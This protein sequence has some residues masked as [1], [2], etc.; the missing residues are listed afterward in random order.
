MDKSAMRAAAQRLLE[1]SLRFWLE[2]MTDNRNGGFYGRIDGNGILHPDAP[3]GAVL[4]ARILWSF[5][6]AYR[7]TRN[8]QYLEAAARAEH[9]LLEKF[10]DHDF[11]GVY[12]SLTADGKPLD[13]RKQIYALG[14]AVYGLSEYA[15]ATGD[16][17]AEEAAVKL[18]DDIE[19]HSFDSQQNGY[20]EAF[21]RQWNPIDDMRLSEKDANECKTMNT[22]LHIMEPYTNLYRLRRDERL[23]ERLVNLLHIFSE[24]I[25]DPRN[26]HL[27]LFFDE[28]WRQAERGISYG[29][30]IEASW[31]LLEA[32]LEIG[33]EKLTESVKQLCSIIARA[34]GEGLRP[35]GSMIYERHADGTTDEERHW[36]VQA[37]NTVGQLWL[38]RYHNDQEAARRAAESL[39]YITRQIA[40][41]DGEWLWGRHADG[42]PDTE[43]DLAGFWKCP[44]HNTRMCLEI[45]RLT[46]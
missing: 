39:D 29:H 42:Q 30:D 9:Y 38:H 17:R 6:A 1:N 10:C 13:T 37:E 46:E 3:K 15:L 16:T 43:N 18:F 28:Q 41:A 21:T 12:W 26:G 2:R 19:Q 36:W 27:G 8:P 5:S 34:A 11:G 33:D 23:R 40:V 35:D 32:A 4:N 7:A 45:M 25:F 20:L 44:Y 31:L 24:R 22:H 14:F